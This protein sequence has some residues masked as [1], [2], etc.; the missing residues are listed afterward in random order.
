MRSFIGP[1]AHYAPNAAIQPC[2]FV[3][4]LKKDAHTLHQTGRNF[5]AI[6]SIVLRVSLQPREVARH[7]CLTH[8]VLID[9][10]DEY[11]LLS[12]LTR[13]ALQCPE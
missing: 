6:E 2:N 8:A 1:S 9:F 10:L 13:E 5:P 4:R 12:A 3:T 11:R 7:K